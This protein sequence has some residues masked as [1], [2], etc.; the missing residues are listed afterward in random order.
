MNFERLSGFCA[1][2]FAIDICLLDEEGL[3]L[4]LYKRYSLSYMVI[5]P[6]DLYLQ[7]GL[8][9]PCCCIVSETREM[10]G[11]CR[12][13]AVVASSIVDIKGGQIVP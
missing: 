8:C 7:E 3:V 2:P 4:K 9:G 11:W 1:D 12:D 13:I 5:I 10:R 6:I